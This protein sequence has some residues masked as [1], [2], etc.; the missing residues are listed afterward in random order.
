MIR[1]LGQRFIV[2]T[3]NAFGIA[4]ADRGKASVLWQWTAITE[5]IS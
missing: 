5:L 3:R 2:D 4:V 1:E